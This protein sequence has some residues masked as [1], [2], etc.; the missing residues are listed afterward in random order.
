MSS[1][2]IP[3]NACHG[4]ITLKQTIQLDFAAD[5]SDV[6]T[7]VVFSSIYRF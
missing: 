1:S 7:T 5:V 3:D 6:D 2:E 4:Q